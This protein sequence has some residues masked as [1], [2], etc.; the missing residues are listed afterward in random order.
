MHSGLGLGLSIVKSLVESHSGTVTVHS[1]GQGRGATFSVL[2]PIAVCATSSQPAIA[3]APSL[4]D[5]F[6]HGVPSLE[7]ISVLVVDDDD[8]S[9]EVVAAHLLGCNA[10]VLTASSA[11]LAFDMLQH[12]DV[13]VLLADIGMPDEDG[14]ALIRRIRSLSRPATAAI[15]AAALTAFARDEDRQRA[16][17]AGFQLH[18]PKPIDASSL[19]SAVATLG[20][21]KLTGPE[22]IPLPGMRPDLQAPSRPLPGRIG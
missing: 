7:G 10:V 21:M 3:D 20:R 14:Y 6:A 22:R 2:L 5:A 18:L 13:D 11:A 19:V 17:Q 1:A 9:R 16:L 12:E 15:P 8:Q 4:S